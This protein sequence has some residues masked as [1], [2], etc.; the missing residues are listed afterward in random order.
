MADGFYRHHIFFCTNRRPDCKDCC[1]QRAPVDELRMY[2]KDRLKALG[3]FGPGAVRVSSSG[4]LGRCDDGPVAVV[5][6]EGIWYTF[7]DRD[8]I[9]EIVERHLRDGEIVQRLR[10]TRT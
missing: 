5:Y 3:L 8:D 2:A 9:D 7:V 1:A 10:L 4:C 6:P